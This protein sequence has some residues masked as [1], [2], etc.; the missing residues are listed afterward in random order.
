MLAETSTYDTIWEFR[1]AGGSLCTTGSTCDG[2]WNLRITRVTVY[3]HPS[4][5]ADRL[6]HPPA[7]WV[8]GMDTQVLHS[9]RLQSGM[10][11][12]DTVQKVEVEQSSQTHQARLLPN[13]P[14]LKA[15]Y[16]DCCT[17]CNISMRV[18]KCLVLCQCLGF[19][20]GLAMV[21]WRSCW[22]SACS[23]SGLGSVPVSRCCACVR[24][25]LL[26]FLLVSAL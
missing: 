4:P 6:V 2:T 25:G 21:C 15:V 14:A 19:S 1:N 8:I 18:K 24:N 16:F 13:C 26:V 20:H 5:L 10:P 9:W 7:V 23:I 22:A 11:S 3:L 12:C 17:D